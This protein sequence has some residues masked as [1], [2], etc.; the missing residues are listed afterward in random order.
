[1]ALDRLG[2]FA[3]LS[4]LRACSA[5]L[6]LGVA[7]APVLAQEDD[8]EREEI[9]QQEAGQVGDSA[10]GQAGQRITRETAPVVVKPL[11]AIASRVQNRVQSRLRNRIDR[12]YDPQANAQSPFAVAEQDA[13]VAGRR[14]RR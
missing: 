9:R 13:R 6:F 5:A 10:V 4:L 14:R 2:A 7:A 11:S 3:R 8:P 12:F 1:V